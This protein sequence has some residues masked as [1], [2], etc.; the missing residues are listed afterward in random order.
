MGAAPA[1]GVTRTPGPGGPRPVRVS[2]EGWDAGPWRSDRPRT[3][4]G[5][6]LRELGCGARG[7]PVGLTCAVPQ[8][9]PGR[10]D[11]RTREPPGSAEGLGTEKPRRAPGVWRSKKIVSRPWRPAPPLF[12]I[13]TPSPGNARGIWRARPSR[14]RFSASRPSPARR[15]LYCRLVLVLLALV[16]CCLPAFCDFLVVPPEPRASPRFES[17]ALSPLILP[18]PIARPPS[19]VSVG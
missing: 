5:L 10:R 6:L 3:T 14:S 12:D 8:A 1:A 16:L 9:R 7:R 17:A 19:I 2:S 18:L 13:A 15:E 4:A 11:R